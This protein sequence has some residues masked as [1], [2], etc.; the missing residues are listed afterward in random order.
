[1]SELRSAPTKAVPCYELR[2]A[3]TAAYTRSAIRS[4]RLSPRGVETPDTTNQRDQSG[5]TQNPQ[6]TPVRTPSIAVCV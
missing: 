1:M 2:S 4:P 3:N 6:R 5:L